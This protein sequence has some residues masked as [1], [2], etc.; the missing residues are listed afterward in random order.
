MRE[1]IN[2]SFN[3]ISSEDM[4]VYIAHEGGGLFEENFLPT[5]S[6]VE[7]KVAKRDKPYFQ[8]VEYE[9]LSFTL[10]IFIEEWKHRDNLRQIAKWLFQEYY[11]PLQFET[12]SNRIFYAI[13][14]GDSSLIHNGMKKGYVTLNI[15]CNSPFSYSKPNL[16]EGIKGSN[17]LYKVLNSGDMIIKPK[18][19]ITKTVTDGDLSIENENTGQ[20]MTISN[21]QVNE[22]V[23]LNGENEEIVS[24]L[25]ILNVYRH[26][27]HNDV[28]LDL[29][30]GDN[31]LILTGDFILEIEYQLIYL[32]D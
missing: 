25:E 6:I 2:F 18:I 3:G 9:P 15:R 26:N 23:Y 10:T 21:L 22:Q 32:A 11:Q 28:W 24:S 20:T 1:S 5:R 16:H 14:E 17:G 29:E 8:R 13:V 27:D 4:G 7:T 30:V 12:N 31:S 19:W